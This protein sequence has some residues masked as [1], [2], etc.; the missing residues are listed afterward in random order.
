MDVVPEGAREVVRLCA[1]ACRV[2]ADSAKAARDAVFMVDGVK[3]E[4]G[5][6]D[7]QAVGLSRTPPT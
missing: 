5:G 3:G 1:E 7:M 6:G 4:V 2:S